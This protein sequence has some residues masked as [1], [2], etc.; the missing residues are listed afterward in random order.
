MTVHMYNFAGGW[1]RNRW[2]YKNV[3]N[4]LHKYAVSMHY[5]KI[6]KAICV[7]VFVHFHIL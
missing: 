6:A 3:T 5:N 4:I 2:M 1:V 7:C